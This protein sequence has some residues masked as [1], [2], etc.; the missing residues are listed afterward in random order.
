MIATNMIK[1]VYVSETFQRRLADL[2]RSGGTASL[3]AGR[4][5]AIIERATSR[6]I[7]DPR[8]LGRLTKRGE[9]RIVNCLK[10]DLGRGYRLV[11]V[12]KNREFFVLFIGSHDECQRWLKRNQKVRPLG[13][14][15]TVTELE[16]ESGAREPEPGGVSLIHEPDEYEENLMR[17]IDDR[18][19]REVFSG[20]VGN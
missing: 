15:E 8:R 9:A 11:A 10:Y 12:L 5:Q 18:I 17:L 20:L 16:V 7:K 13:H 14:D 6:G 4:A 19:L 1:R 2:L 3:I